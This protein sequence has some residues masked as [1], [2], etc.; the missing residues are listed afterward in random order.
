MAAYSTISTI[1]GTPTE[2]IFV[3]AIID[4][5]RNGLTTRQKLHKETMLTLL[6]VNN[7][8]NYV[9]ITVNNKHSN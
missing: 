9:N 3:E 2:N 4:E 8:I 6:Q 5:I 7:N 1:P